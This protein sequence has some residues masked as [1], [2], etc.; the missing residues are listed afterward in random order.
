MRKYTVHE[1]NDG[2]IHFYNYYA[3]TEAELVKV[4]L[5]DYIINWLSEDTEQTQEELKEWFSDCETIVELNKAIGFSWYSV[6]IDSSEKLYQ[7]TE[8]DEF[9][10]SFVDEV[11][12]DLEDVLGCLT[13]KTLDELHRVIFY[14]KNDILVDYACFI[15]YNDETVTYLKIL[16]GFLMTFTGDPLSSED[17][18]NILKLPLDC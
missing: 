7:G 4:M 9:P 12:S 6:E 11:K 1:N 16:N 13:K 3:D 2:I 18:V 5:D 17:V 8:A 14:H 10:S 15:K